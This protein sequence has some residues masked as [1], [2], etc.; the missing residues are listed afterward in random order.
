[1]RIHLV[2]EYFEFLEAIKQIGKM[3]STSLRDLAN[4]ALSSWRPSSSV[5]GIA[6]VVCAHLLGIPSI[7]SSVVLL[8]FLGRVQ[9]GLGSYDPGD[10]AQC[11]CV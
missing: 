5:A 11:V 9:T 4:G 8:F 2:Q 6:S 10:A 3:A 7:P 1:M